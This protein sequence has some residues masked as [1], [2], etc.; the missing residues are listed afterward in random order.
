MPALDMFSM[1]IFYINLERQ[2]I[3]PGSRFN[4]IQLQ[5]YDFLV[6]WHKQG[7]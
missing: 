2:N 6:S 5:W 1:W 7:G 3:A 4:H